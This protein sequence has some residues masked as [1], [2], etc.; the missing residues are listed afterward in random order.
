MTAPTP[1]VATIRP[2]T[3]MFWFIRMSYLASPHFNLEGRTAKPFS[4]SQPA[5]SLKDVV[6][7]TLFSRHFRSFRFELIR[8]WPADGCCQTV[9]AAAKSLC[10]RQFWCILDFIAGENDR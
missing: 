9:T 1:S 2:K 10:N 8:T 3:M 6:R 7:T 4:V 5:Y